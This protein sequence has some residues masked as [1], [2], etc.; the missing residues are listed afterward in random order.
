[1]PRK[2]VKL[3][4]KLFAELPGILAWAVAG[5]RTWLRDGLGGAAAVDAAT[6]EY[7]GE[8]DLVGRF[9][10]SDVLVQ[11]P[12]FEIK[13]TQ[14]YALYARWCEESGERPISGTKFGRMMHARGLSKEERKRGNY[15]LGYAEATDGAANSRRYAGADFE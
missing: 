13:A 6:K 9:L 2:D 12:G 4:E 15:Y 7:R 11:G 10:A 1:D 5:A 8:S 3:E 14:L